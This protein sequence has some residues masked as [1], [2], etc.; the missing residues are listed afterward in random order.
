ML[1]C[2]C[3]CIFLAY[4]SDLPEPPGLHFQRVAYSKLIQSLAEPGE[5]RM[6]GECEME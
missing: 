5:G 6:F 3:P 4:P 1:I 2:H